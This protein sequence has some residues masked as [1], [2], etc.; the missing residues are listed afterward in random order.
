[1]EVKHPKRFN[2]VGPCVPDEHYMLP[3]LPRLP[4]VDEMIEGKFYFI[5]HAPRQSGK[6]TFLD[7]LTD[8]IN[9][10][11]H[12]YALNVSLASL[13]NFADPTI[14]LNGVISQLNEAMVSSQ[15]ESIKQKADTYD[16]LPGMSAPDRMVKRFLNK[17]CEDLDKEL[18]VFFDEADCLQEAPLIPFLSQIRD[19]YNIRHKK[20]NKFP[21]SIALVGMRDIR[22]YLAQVRPDEESRGLASPFN[23][24]KEA[25][26]LPNFTEREIG[27]LYRQHTEATGQVFEE[28]SA[29]KAWYWSEGQ[30]WLV[31]ALADAVITKQ[32]NKDFS[33]AI[34]NDH[35]DKAADFLIQ[36]RDTHIDSLLERLKEPRVIN[37]MDG[38]FSGSPSAV[39]YKNDDRQYCI[40]LGLVTEQENGALR[41]SNQ[42]YKEVMSRVITDEI[43]HILNINIEHKF[44]SDGKVLFISEILK[45]FQRFFRH[46]SDSFPLRNRN[47]TAYKYDE[48]TFSFM[49]EAYLQFAFN[50]SAS[51]YRQFAEGRGAVDLAVLYH[52]REY[53][54]EVKLKENTTLPKT[55]NQFSGYL[56]KAGESEG[57]VVIFDRDQKK[58]WEEKTYWE[59]KHVN[60]LIIHIVGC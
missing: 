22:D 58:S 10:E 45:E 51:I 9:S 48:A 6:T 8:K 53:L 14:G 7:V 42:I 33:V 37:V 15:V 29:T 57:W 5:L 52:G 28:S 56:D 4:S 17:L 1:M 27:T 19:G 13:R 18:V 35:I 21:R 59:T 46:D 41:P 16:S 49:L 25:F 54:I 3:V 55:L 26:T 43:Q 20:G 23:I 44:W 34:T 47:L 60:N 12:I 2:T 11:G 30:P 36:R 50:S 39:P 31:N 40:D 38:V 32:L 24:K